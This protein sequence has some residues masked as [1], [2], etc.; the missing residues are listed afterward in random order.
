MCQ[1]GREAVSEKVCVSVHRHVSV[2]ELYVYMQAICL[3]ACFV[4]HLFGLVRH[5]CGSRHHLGSHLAA[6]CNG[7]E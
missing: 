7:R 6:K 2:L 3:C 5:L 1:D 4:F